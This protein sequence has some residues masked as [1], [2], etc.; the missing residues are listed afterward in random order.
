M[1]KFTK[2]PD[3]FCSI[4]FTIF[5]VFCIY[6]IYNCH[7]PN[8]TFNLNLL[9]FRNAWIQSFWLFF[10]EYVLLY[11]LTHLLC[12]RKAWMQSICL[13][14]CKSGWHNKSNP[15]NVAS[16]NGKSFSKMLYWHSWS[17][18]VERLIPTSFGWSDSWTVDPATSMCVKIVCY[19]SVTTVPWH[20]EWTVNIGIAHHTLFCYY[21]CNRMDLLL[22]VHLQ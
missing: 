12:Y 2:F 10:R 1:S 14:L 3:H 7:F 16:R 13:F 11:L 15:L 21:S 17:I 19:N 18:H 22:M 4:W 20:A 9:C 6:F 5:N 8:Y